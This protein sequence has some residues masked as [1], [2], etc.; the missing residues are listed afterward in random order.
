MATEDVLRRMRA[1]DVPAVMEVQEPTSVAG[2]SGVFPQDAHPFPREVLAGRW[3]EEIDDPAIE[4][5]VIERAGAVAG[6]AALAGGI[7]APVRQTTLP[8]WTGVA[9]R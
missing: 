1:D 3:R 7:G 9:A 4:C 6:F 5:F 8:R 2:L